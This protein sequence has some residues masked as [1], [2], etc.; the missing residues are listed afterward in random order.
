MKAS[1]L[2]GLFTS[3]G[4]ESLFVLYAAN[5]HKKQLRYPIGTRLLHVAF[6]SIHLH[7]DLLVVHTYNITRILQ[8]HTLLGNFHHILHSNFFILAFMTRC[9]DP[10]SFFQLYLTIR[11]N[12]YSQSILP[13]F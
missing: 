2:V 11:S 4:L 8:D 12:S 3:N 1:R 10:S 7:F 9:S 6:H 13:I 5:N